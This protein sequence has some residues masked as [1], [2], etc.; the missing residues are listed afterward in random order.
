[1]ICIPLELEQ[2]KVSCALF[3]SPKENETI[4]IMIINEKQC[5]IDSILQA[6]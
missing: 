2:E 3:L 1:M 6:A 4:T 5:I